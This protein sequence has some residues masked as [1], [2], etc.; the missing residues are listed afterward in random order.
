MVKES[1]KYIKMNFLRSIIVDNNYCKYINDAGQESY[2]K[3]FGFK[4]EDNFFEFNKLNNTNNP[5]SFGSASQIQNIM[6]SIRE[7]SFSSS[8]YVIEIINKMTNNQVIIVDNKFSLFHIFK[9]Y[10]K[11][12]KQHLKIILSYRNI[13]MECKEMLVIKN[14]KIFT[15]EEL[16]TIEIMIYEYKNEF[17]NVYKI[18]LK[19]KKG[20]KTDLYSS[21]EFLL[22]DNL[23]RES[24][25]SYVKEN[26]TIDDQVDSDSIMNNASEYINL[27]KLTNY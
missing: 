25:I 14:T 19:N 17:K 16:E 27:I 21:S 20:Y 22:K 24:F 26:L 5:F 13:N 9:N 11:K 18:S 12:R 6:K 7:Q 8:E 2:V 15:N 4:W 10:I 1:H 23:F 3:I